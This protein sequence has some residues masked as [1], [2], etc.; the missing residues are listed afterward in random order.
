MRN[1]KGLYFEGDNDAMEYFFDKL[2]DRLGNGGINII[3]INPEFA[4]C[5]DSA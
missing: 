3:E 2:R 4:N 5:E 1:I